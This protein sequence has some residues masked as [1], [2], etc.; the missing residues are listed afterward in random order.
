MTPALWA[1]V[2]DR[3]APGVRLVVDEAFAKTPTPAPYDI[4]NIA[5][6][7]GWERPEWAMAVFGLLPIESPAP[8]AFPW[9]S[10]DRPGNLLIHTRLHEKYYRLF[11]ETRTA[12]WTPKASITRGYTHLTVV[13]P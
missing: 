13:Q 4:L 9:A 1:T 3:A 5:D 8:G 2:R 7:E 6:A 12:G 11:A 10:V